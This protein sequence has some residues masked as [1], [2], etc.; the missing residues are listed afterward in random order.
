MRTRRSLIKATASGVAFGSAAISGCV[1]TGEETDDEV[2]FT[3]AGA[4]LPGPNDLDGPQPAGMT[5]L[6][7][8]LTE[9]DDRLQPSVVGENQLCG[10]ED[11]PARLMEGVIEV[12]GT[13]M[14]NS[15]A[16]WPV[17]DIWLL[18]YTFPSSESLAYTISKE[19]TWENYW[20]P[21]AEEF[22]S[23]PFYFMSPHLRNIGIGTDTVE[24]TDGEFR[25]PEDINGLSI[26]RTESSVSSIAIENFGGNPSNV[27]WGDTVQG[28]QSGVVDGAESWNSAFVAFG[29][30][31][32]LGAVILNEWAIGFEVI[33]ADVEWLQQLPEWALEVI[34][35]ET[36][37]LNN[38]LFQ[39][40]DEIENERIGESDPPADGSAFAEEGITV[41][42]L[43]E[44]ERDEWRSLV[45]VEDNMNLYEDVLD[46]GDRIGIDG[47]EFH[48]YLH[49]SARE[50]GVP[51][52]LEGFEVDTWWDEYLNQI[53]L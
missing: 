9:A 6:S 11:C 39:I 26:R 23:I 16:H 50:S 14:G 31:E 42:E 41:A 48:E 44:D 49:D 18:P 21:F 3:M 36:R 51:S 19:E 2:E 29:M 34:A 13:S 32:S 28:L 4:F 38:Y 5:E 12:S 43:D 30:A 52:S 37:E 17:N 15:T 27:A 1:D 53:E 47:R 8:R 33:W 24:D 10:E 7:N 40:T 45:S 22:G 20:I 25:T 46:H 35:E